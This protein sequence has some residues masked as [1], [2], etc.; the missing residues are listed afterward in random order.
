MIFR[1]LIYILQ[2]EYY[3]IGRFLRY[4]YSHPRWW[5][6]ECRGKLRWTQK[7][8]MLY[9]LGLSL[10]L[11]LVLLGFLC[12]GWYGWL[13]SCLLVVASPLSISLSTVLLS[14]I[15]RFL[16][17]RKI[18]TARAVVERSNA[19]VIGITGSY[20]KTSMKEILSALLEGSF[21]V[22]K[23][24]ENINTD[25][26]VADFI[27]ANQ[28]GILGAEV[29]IVEMGAHGLGD[30]RALCDLVRPQY[31]ILTGIG[32]AHL[33]RFG[34]MENIVRGKFELSQATRTCAFFN[35]DSPP[36]CEALTVERT[37]MTCEVVTVSG[38]DA[39][40]IGLLENFAGLS[41]VWQGER[42]SIQLLGRH[43]VALFVLGMTL[44]RKLEVPFDRLRE[45]VAGVTPV[46]H[47][48]QP[49]RNSATDVWVLDDSYN[50]N[51]DGA[52]SAL[53]VLSRA[54]GR[55]VVLTPGLVEL[56]ESSERIHR[57][58]AAEYMRVADQALLIRSDATNFMEAYF[59]EKG[60]TGFITYGTTAEAHADLSRVLRRGDTILFQNDLSDNYF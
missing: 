8:R 49:I 16:K 23:T 50:G 58:L 31:S 42:F 44:A 45:R 46:K 60:Y 41:F 59:A 5:R 56:G 2:S 18:A 47:R 25:I 12:F 13:I 22:V 14:P 29:F 36:I 10:S 57:E 38:G 39:T 28:E 21:V 35:V 55:K 48:L 7:S 1:N 51:R 27:L 20:G 6:L 17:E 9:A 53:E 32:E 30:V 43:A 4:A 26:G 52:L 34:S 11:A 3:D 54:K 19:K 37:S 40:A 24:P 15:D 33:E